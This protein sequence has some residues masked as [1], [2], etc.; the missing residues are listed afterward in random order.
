MILIERGV[1]AD[2]AHVDIDDPVA[3][4]FRLDIPDARRPGVVDSIC[5]GTDQC[6]GFAHLRDGWLYV[7]TPVGLDCF[8]ELAAL[9]TS[10]PE[11]EVKAVLQTLEQARLA[12]FV[13]GETNGSIYFGR[14]TDGFG[15]LFFG[16]GSGSRLVISD[17]RLILA[18]TLGELAFSRADEEH[19][20]SRFILEPEGSFLQGVK[21]CFA[22]IRYCSGPEAPYAPRGKVMDP[23]ADVVSDA[24]S[25]SYLGHEL[26]KVLSTYG[27]KRIAL[28]LSGGLDS[29]VVLVAILDA[30]RRGILRREQIL[31]VSALFPG[32]DCDES[33]EI[34]Q[35]AGLAGLE[36]LGIDISTSLVESTLEHCLDLPAPPFPT[37]FVAAACMMEAKRHG[38]QIV[39]SGHGG[40]EIFD[41]DLADVLTLPMRERMRRYPMIRRF[42]R[43]DSWIGKGKVL[44]SIVAGSWT[45]RSARR[46]LRAFPFG[47]ALAIAH[48]PGRRLGLAQHCGYEVSACAAAS[49]GLLRDAP[50]FRA[51]LFSRLTPIGQRPSSHSYKHLARAYME[52]QEPD[53]ASVP[54]RKVL[55]ESAV[56]TFFP[57]S[58][59]DGQGTIG[60]AYLHVVKAQYSDWRSRQSRQ[61]RRPPA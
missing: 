14:S 58:G 32:L 29:R 6:S 20:C 46:S 8:P 43:T 49:L 16:G 55:F 48:R 25:T 1:A 60:P 44:G 34:S 61:Y 41:F 26:L 39:I 42:R 5:Y 12:V 45:L 33:N 7:S 47:D 40:D 51:A 35:I 10:G 28:L 17:S 57:V 18:R 59:R 23:E 9:I 13:V 52:A 37:S 21:R 11:L 4:Y 56:N 53:I 30:I 36:W 15:S 3:S 27:N 54:A 31:C 24:D 2:R 50:L 19:W 22:G 38:A